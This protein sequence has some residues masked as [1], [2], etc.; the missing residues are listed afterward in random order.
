[1]LNTLMSD[2]QDD[3]ND[4]K[5]DNEEV[6]VPSINLETQKEAPISIDDSIMMSD[7]SMVQI[8]QT[9]NNKIEN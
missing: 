1:M 6:K 7:R 3:K 8:N 9:Q 5:I 4:Q 2:N